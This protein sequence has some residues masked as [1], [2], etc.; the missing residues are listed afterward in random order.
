MPKRGR[1]LTREAERE[2]ERDRLRKTEVE[3][4]ANLHFCGNANDSEFRNKV[5]WTLSDRALQEMT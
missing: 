1:E 3:T 4:M 5:Q 2:R